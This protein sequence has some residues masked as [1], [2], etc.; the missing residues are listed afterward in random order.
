MEKISLDL[1]NNIYENSLLLPET[2]WGIKFFPVYSW[3][4]TILAD[5]GRTFFCSRAHENGKAIHTP[6]NNSLLVEYF[7]FRLGVANGE[8]VTM[9][10]LVSYGRTD[11]DFYKIDEEN[12]YMDFSV[13]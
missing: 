9:E 13:K 12:Y 4:F 11:I 3:Y 2:L 6:H 8:L 7:R 5:D 1:N 10:H